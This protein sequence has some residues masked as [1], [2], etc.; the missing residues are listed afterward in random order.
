MDK[1]Q[2]IIT[3]RFWILGF[4]TLPLA[5]Y[6]FFSAN[7]ALKAETESRETTLQQTLTGVPKGT[8]DPNEDYQTKL[9]EI[10]EQFEAN[11]EESI[12]DIWNR[13]KSRMTWPPVV[14]D[15][16][17]E[18]FLGKIELDVTNIYRNEY[19]RL[20]RE[21]QSRVQP[22]MPIENKPAI[23]GIGL[24]GIRP[25]A[26]KEADVDWPQKVVYAAD[27]PV[28]AFNELSVPPIQVW[29]AQ[30][31]IWLVD[32]I[33]EAIRNINE[34]KDS[35]TEADIRRVDEFRLFGGTGV[36][37]IGGAGAAGAEGGYGG[38]YGGSEYGGGGEYG[39][40]AGSY[41]AG[42]YG[43]GGY[44]AGGAGAASASIKVNIAFDPAEEYGPSGA[45][46]AAAASYGGYS[47]AS[48]G[49]EYGGETAAPAAA[50]GS[51]SRYIG[52]SEE[53]KVLERGFYLSVIIKQERIPDFVVELANSDWPIRVTRFHVGKNPHYSERPSPGVGGY[54]AG[55]MLGMEMG[56]YGE[57]AGGYG[58][59]GIGG[60]EGEGLGMLGGYGAGARAKKIEGVGNLTSN[61]PPYADAAMNNPDLV[62]L[63]L[64][65]VITMF[66]QPQEVID[67]LIADG[68]SDGE[69]ADPTLAE[70]TPPEPAIDETE[71]PVATEETEVPLTEETTDETE[72]AQPDASATDEP[73]STEEDTPQN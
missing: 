21:L 43:A 4:L 44:G 17:P 16:I 67:A 29:N 14:A 35:V 71:T 11:V 13:Q 33:F 59:A 22:V 47:S 39:G 58:E 63:D 60:Y 73:A 70:P 61:L 31:D 36:P 66:K 23:G 5:M 68:S 52:D 12:V 10:N 26:K 42:G 37:T 7:N 34:E 41:G 56:G 8:N 64:C 55:A 57:S 3:H 1:L 72:A 27:L 69:L 65:G 32:L 38:E 24:G 6:G 40:T 9:A 51:S 46:G 28:A 62:Q 2:P 54:G 18:L 48:Y 20:M 19:D 30:I 50:G 53:K 25:S 15:E 45:G 49:S